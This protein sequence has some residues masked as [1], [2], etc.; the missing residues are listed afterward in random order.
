[1]TLSHL[2][3]EGLDFLYQAICTE[4]V[5]TSGTASYKQ[6]EEPDGSDNWNK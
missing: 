2:T 6:N 1:M 4:S 5:V 3:Q